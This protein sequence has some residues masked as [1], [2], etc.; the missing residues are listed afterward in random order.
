MK[1]FWLWLLAT[2]GVLLVV[3][4]IGFGFW[5]RGARVRYEAKIAALQAA[6][7]PIRH[8][9]LQTPEIPYEENA[10]PLLEEAWAWV[11]ANA[12]AKDWP[13]LSFSNPRLPPDHPA[14]VSAFLSGLDPCFRKID[15]ALEK[16]GHWVPRDPSGRH[17]GGYALQQLSRLAHADGLL[18]PDT[19][20]GTGRTLRRTAQLLK[21]ASF[22]RGRTL[23]SH[24]MG[25]SQQE[26]ALELL[27]LAAARKDF[28]PAEARGTL[29]PLLSARDQGLP[30]LSRALEGE[31]VSI[32]DLCEGMVD[33]RK[34]LSPAIVRYTGTGW[35]RPFVH[36]NALRVLD[37]FDALDRLCGEEPHRAAAEMQRLEAERTAARKKNN[38]LTMGMGLVPD[39]RSTFREQ[40]RMTV[41]L[42]LA[43]L[44]LAA[45]D[46]AETGT[47]PEAR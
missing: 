7:K 42:R 18:T 34:D 16:P 30:P 8:S 21:W 33:G 20:E 1:K 41:E 4:A 23:M 46:G 26:K 25:L 40:I 28:D 27:R 47:W 38:P 36:E 35:Y 5:S 32:L 39:L 31:R 37:H 11:E 17:H 2:L 15:E 10:A 19:P 12:P 29:E 6:G 14:T 24:F 22:E 3:V 9:D 44:A 13:E 45:L 43:R